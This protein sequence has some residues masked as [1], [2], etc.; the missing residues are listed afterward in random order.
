[1][2]PVVDENGNVTGKVPRSVCHFNPVEKILHPVVH[3]HVFNSSGDIFLQ[4]RAMTKKVQPGKWD[5]AVGGHISFGEDLELSL[6]REAKEEIGIFG[7]KPE[8]VQKYIWETE[9]EKELVFMFVCNSN[10]SLTVNPEEISEGRFWEISEIRNSLGKGIF[11]GNFEKE[12]L[13]LTGN[14]TL[15]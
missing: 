10:G 13:I 11:T 7:F 9:V 3:M 6:Q 4:H 12:F 1:M 2:L 5:T 8:F 15:S 14:K